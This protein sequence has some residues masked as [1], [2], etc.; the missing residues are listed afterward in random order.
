MGTVFFD[1]IAQFDQTALRHK[2][3]DERFVVSE[4]DVSGFAGS[5]EDVQRRFFF[6]AGDDDPFNFDI[7]WI[8]EVLLNPFGPCVVVHGC[9][10]GDATVEHGDFQCDRL[11]IAEY[12]FRHGDEWEEGQA[13][14]QHQNHGK[15]F[16]HGVTSFLFFQ[17][18]YGLQGF[19]AARSA[20]YSFTAPIITP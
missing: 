8:A 5:H 7:A 6:G 14:Y 20:F 18:F 4:A 15:Q 1:Q 11:V 19:R 3:G 17:P 9:A 2:V 16:F 10:A 13:H 12:V